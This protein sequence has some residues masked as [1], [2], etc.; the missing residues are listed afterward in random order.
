MTSMLGPAWTLKPDAP[1]DTGRQ[2]LAVETVIGT[3]A[4]ALIPGV[5][6]TTPHARYLALHARLA[7][8]AQRHG[9]TD[10]TDLE[11][12]R[13]LVRRAEVVLG[14]VSVAH[15]EADHDHHLRAGSFGVHGVNTVRPELDRERA[16]DVGRV[17]DAYS[18]VPGGY[19]QTYAGIEAVLGLT[20]GG[21]IPLPGSAANADQLAA[22][23]EVLSVAERRRPLSVADL[24]ALRHLCVCAIGDAPDGACVRNAYFVDRGRLGYARTH[25]R[26]AALLVGA[27]TG[28]QVDAESIDM[29]MDR[30]CC[31]RPGLLELV[32]E[33]LHPHALVWRG[34]LL[35]NWSVWAWRLI[36]AR[37]VS[38]LST[39]GTLEQA[40]AEFVRALPDAT[41][42]EA[43]V[44]GLPPVIDNAG[45]PLPVEHDL[46][47]DALDVD[48]WTVLGMLRL[49]AV[50]ARR[51]DHL[52]PVT[53]DAFVGAFADD[54]GPGYVAEWLDRDA[55]RP[56]AEAV[57]NL[58]AALFHRAESVSRQKMQW[59]RYGLRLPTRLRRVGDRWRLEG[60]EGRGA[61]SLRLPTFTN[62]MQ[63]LDVV[64]HDGGS[65]RP[66]RHAPE[67]TS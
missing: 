9:W 22:L 41:V 12:F 4:A 11:R 30:W 58:A 33:D 8:E 42:R 48:D 46:Y 62:V 37:L 36:W 34:A 49:L 29:S 45:T 61:V 1:D 44:D 64:A 26:S 24:D 43:L 19:L 5:I 60:R 54:L 21:R 63:Q 14:A 13:A 66:G 32:G 35:R 38:P 16:V 17:A 67:V 31:F 23:D 6:T 39:A 51:L 56:L 2:P 47:R 15:D 55:D 28:E 59:T 10:K 53:R 52:D 57:S 40:I 25:R 50:G 3:H 7:I 18:R 65:W 20:D 27:L